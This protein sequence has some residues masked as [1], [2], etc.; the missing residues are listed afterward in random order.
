MSKPKSK[1]EKK[2]D[3]NI[4][5][6]LTE[7]CEQCLGELPGFQ[8]LTHQANY[9]NF[10]ASLLVT[11]VFDSEAHRQQAEASGE[12]QKLQKQIQVRLLKIGVK[13]KA[14]SRQVLFDSEELC[15][16]Q[17]AGDWAARLASRE[18]RAVSPNRPH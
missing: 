8:W 6:A 13:F 16:Q 1:T 2:I 4:R 18:G 7:V 17:H 5:V 12:T 3:N 14:L 9:T 15:D 11:C 10:P